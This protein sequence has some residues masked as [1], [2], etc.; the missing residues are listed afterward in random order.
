MDKFVL[1]TMF[2]LDVCCVMLIAESSSWEMFVGT[3]IRLES[4]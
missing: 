4:E 1:L 3:Y 2:P